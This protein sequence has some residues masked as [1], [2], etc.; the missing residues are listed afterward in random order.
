[1]EDDAE[2]TLLRSDVQLRLFP[3]VTADWAYR[4]PRV[5]PGLTAN[6][7]AV[8]T[9]R[10]PEP[11]P[12]RASPAKSANVSAFPDLSQDVDAELAVLH[13]QVWRRPSPFVEQDE[14]AVSP[15]LSIA[16]LPST[17]PLGRSAGARAPSA[18]PSPSVVSVHPAE[19]ASADKVA[20]VLGSGVADSSSSRH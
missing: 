1:M 11:A 15:S 8:V 4:F 13:T 14:P 20:S 19:H 16:P 9:P 5:F 10:A 6:R 18:A 17:E 2:L 3:Y 7:L 12:S